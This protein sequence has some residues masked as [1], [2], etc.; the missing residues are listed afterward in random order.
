MPPTLRIH[1]LEDSGDARGGNF[2]IPNSSLEFLGSVCDVHFAEIRPGAI[3]GNH[4]H[5][6]RRKMLCVHHTDAWSLHWDTGPDTPN[7][8]EN[9]EGSGVVIVEIEPLIAH[10]IRNDGRAEMQIVGLSN[11]VFDPNNRETYPRQVV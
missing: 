7:Q 6:H 9:F 11:L 10:A 4:Y 2:S 1:R 8:R 3:R 5:V